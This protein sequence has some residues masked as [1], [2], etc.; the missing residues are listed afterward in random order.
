MTLGPLEI[1]A[2]KLIRPKIAQGC[3]AINELRGDGARKNY[4]L[5]TQKEFEKLDKNP[6]WE[7]SVEYLLYGNHCEGKLDKVIEKTKE[8]VP[9][10]KPVEQP[11][12]P[13]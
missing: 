8:E 2:F 3:I 7:Y 1:R 10:P 13:V 11:P 12:K 5:D 6:A 9:P 4:V